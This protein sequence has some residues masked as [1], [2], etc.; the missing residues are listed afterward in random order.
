MLYQEK[1]FDGEG[2]PA[3]DVTGE[4]IP[5]G[6]RI[7]KAVS[8]YHALRATGLSRQESLTA[9]QSRD[10]WYDPGA[11]RILPRL[12]RL[13]LPPKYGSSLTTR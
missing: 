9:M 10:G 1:R 3:D 5:I 4:G 2:F 12:L 6:S 13:A 11:I 7:L 8:D